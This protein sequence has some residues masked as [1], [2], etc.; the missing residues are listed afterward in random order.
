MR[1]QMKLQPAPF[2]KIKNG[3]KTI[4]IRL[5]DEKR[6]FLKVNDEIEFSL[7]TDPDQKIQTKVLSLLLFATFQELYAA[8]SPEQYGG[9]SKDEYADIYQYY[10]PEDQKK[11][12]VLAIQV[13]LLET[14]TSLEL[15]KQYLHKQVEVV[16]DRP[17]GSTHPTHH[18]VYEANYGFI[19]GVKAPDGENLEYRNFLGVFTLLS[20][21]QR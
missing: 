8:F 21:V 7:A 15:A 16:I 9:M 3:R 12:G 17:L 18:F 4:E 11:Y 2:E 19:A 1:H 10:S 5:N 13:E 20:A 6:Q 14:S